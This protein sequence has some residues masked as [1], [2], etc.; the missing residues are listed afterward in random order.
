MSE[1]LEILSDSAGRQ[2]N[3]AEQLKLHRSKILR[4]VLIITGTVLVGIGVLGIFLPLLPTTVF[5]LLA[6][7]CYARSS[8]KFYH[9]LLHNRWF[10]KY[11]K[12]YRSG[13]GMTLGSKI[14][15]LTFLWA[16]IL[17]SVIFGTENFFVRFI[18]VLI[19]AGVT[20]HLV[21]IKTYKHT[22]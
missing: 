5:F 18:L 15:S 13:N 19:A 6:A 10:G 21:T 4:W 9:W 11:I 3:A 20:L 16:A 17:Y 2:D 1:D 8:E 12:N 7:A 14:F 22:D